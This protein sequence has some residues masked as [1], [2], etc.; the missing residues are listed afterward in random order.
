MPPP[1]VRAEDMKGCGFALDG[2]QRLK[3]DDD[4]WL[5]TTTPT[6]DDLRLKGACDYSFC[7]RGC[8]RTAKYCSIDCK[9]RKVLFYSN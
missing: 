8:A 7:S 1:A 5:A 4:K 2:V 9:V 3:S 6:M